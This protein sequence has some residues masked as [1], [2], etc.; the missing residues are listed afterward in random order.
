MG[1]LWFLVAVTF[2]VLWLN[3]RSGDKSS[4]EDNYG[5]GY[6]DGYRAF[7]DKIA[8]LLNNDQISKHQLQRLIDEGNG[9]T[10]GVSSTRSPVLEEV[11][12]IPEGIDEYDDSV[13]NIPQS[14]ETPAPQPVLTPEEIAAEKDRQTMKNLNLLLYVGSFLIVAAAALF[15]TLVMPASIKLGSLI[16]VT[17]AF[18]VSGLVLHAN[19]SRLRPAAIAFVGTGLAILPFIG[20]ALTSLGGMSGEAAWFVISIIGLIAYGFAAVRLQSQLVSYLTMAFV[21]SVAMS[22]V[23]TLGLSIVWYF[24]MVI[25]VSL[26]CNS[27]HI[28]WPTLMPKVFSQPVEQTGQITTPVAL[29][30]SLFVM[31]EMKLYMYEVLYGVATAHYLVV[32]LE[33]RALMYEVVVRILTHITLLIV[34]A[35]VSQF[36][37]STDEVHRVQFGVWFLA[38]AG[39]QAAYSLLRVR[40]AQHDSWQVEQAALVGSLTTMIIGVVWWADVEYASRWTALSLM[41]TGIT[42]LGAMLRMRQAGWG[43][44]GLFVSILLPYV[45]GRGVFE[46]RL[47]YEVLAGGFAVLSLLALM[48]LDQLRARGRSVGLQN[49]LTIAAVSYALLITLSGYLADASVTIGWTTLLSAGVFVL[50]SYLLREAILEV[51]GAVIGLASIVAWVDVISIEPQWRV[52]VAVTVTAAFSLV[53][54]YVHHFRLEHERRNSLVAFGAIVFAGLVLVTGSDI[55]VGRTAVALL[56]AGGIAAMALRLA[57]KTHSASLLVQISRLAYMGLPLMGLIVST[58]VGVGWLSLVLAVGTVLLWLSSY[59]EKVPAIILAGNAAL[60]CTLASLWSWLEFDSEWQLHG[61]AWLS[62][63]VFYAAY[64]LMVDKKDVWRQWA[65]LGSVWTVLG[66]ATVWSIFDGSTTWVMASAGSLVVGAITLAVQG[67]LSKHREYIEIAVYIATFGMQRMI[68][69]LLPETNLVAYGHWW[70][71]VVGL[72]AWWHGRDYR[73]RAMVALGFVT[74]STGIYALMGTEGYSLVFLIEHLLVLAVGA[75]LRQQWALWWGIV[76]VV[77]AVL[78]S[79]RDFTFLALLFLGFLLILFVI[80]RL[81]K[82]G[83]K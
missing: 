44:A 51:V 10:S 38:L 50:L 55:V 21:L 57:L 76:A 37:T 52:L 35:D 19:S 34:A 6:W 11:G 46:P 1:F 64:W 18:Y 82:M 81:A 9:V 36:A 56:M 13:Q 47:S 54:A 65:F 78:Y 3:A 2:F 15:V 26:I 58:G 71:I 22:A 41:V 61:I 70:A 63:A 20:F 83:K 48:A 17:L 79:L 42:A 72:M 80:W 31:T 14:I 68:S 67:Y 45:V 23:S 59:V 53:A 12:I 28:L 16:F 27:L 75:I 29:V 8:S 77:V 39:A 69:I 25:G 33:K 4:S 7:G 73:V 74:G 49:L 62:A 60:I 32:W 43:Y 5:Q 40:R 30:A 24:I 66:V